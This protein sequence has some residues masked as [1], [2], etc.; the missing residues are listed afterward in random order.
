MCAKSLA[1]RPR[2]ALDFLVEGVDLV[3]FMVRF[4]FWE[5]ILFQITEASA[6]LLVHSRLPLLLSQYNAFGK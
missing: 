6:F 2:G 4:W 5:I 1:G 3:G